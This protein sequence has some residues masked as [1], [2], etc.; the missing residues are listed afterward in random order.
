MQHTRTQFENR[1]HLPRHAEPLRTE[2]H[3]FHLVSC[4]EWK[5]N[6]SN[7]PGKILILKEISDAPYQKN[8]YQ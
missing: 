2:T 4:L 1:I 8:I 5:W 7:Q 3:E 6:P